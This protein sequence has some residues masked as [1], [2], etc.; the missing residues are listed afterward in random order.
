MES[1]ILSRQELYELVWSTPVQF[2][3]RKYGISNHFFYKAC[4]EMAIPLP[5]YRYLGN[6]K[7]GKTE[8]RKE[9]PTD[10]T[11]K[12]EVFFSWEVDPFSPIN[13]EKNILNDT[14]INLVV[15]HNLTN[16]DPLVVAARDSLNRKDLYWRNR[17]RVSTVTGHLSIRVG[18]GN[19]HRALLLMDTLV[20]ALRG[21]G[22]SFSYESNGIVVVILGIS[23]GFGLKEHRDRV[24]TTDRYSSFDLKPTGK[25]YF[26]MGTSYPKVVCIDT[27][28]KLESKLH[29]IIRALELYAE[30]IKRFRDDNQRREDERKEKVRIQQEN[31]ARKQK[32]LDD[33]KDLLAKAKR[34]YQT[35]IIRNYIDL[36]ELKAIEIDNLNEDKKEW[37]DWARRKTNWF[38]PF[39]EADDELLIGAN[40]RSLSFE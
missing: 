40:R 7:S 10:Y 8:E 37:I 11:G 38:D 17:D 36:V 23:V 12:H 3:C 35:E 29:K 34:R 5:G 1:N 26:D 18:K 25:L 15:P 9:L 22:H 6:K 14:S 2:I 4:E 20:K 39:I 13:K 33:F 28:V 32:E 16:P 31:Q 27:K 30:E 19:I 24:E 21:R